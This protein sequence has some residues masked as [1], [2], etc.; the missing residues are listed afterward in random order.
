MKSTKELKMKHVGIICITIASM[1]P[2]WFAQAQQTEDASEFAKTSEGLITDKIPNTIHSAIGMAHAADLPLV[3]RRVEFFFG[4]TKSG[5]RMSNGHYYAAEESKPI[6]SAEEIL[7]DLYARG[8]EELDR[9]RGGS[10]FDRAWLAMCLIRTELHREDIDKKELRYRIE[11]MIDW[12][13]VAKCPESQE[14]LEFDKGRVRFLGTAVLFAEAVG[15]NSIAN[16]AMNYAF[17]ILDNREFDPEFT[18]NILSFAFLQPIRQV[19]DSAIT[20]AIFQHFSSLYSKYIEDNPRNLDIAHAIMLFNR[21]FGEEAVAAIPASGETVSLSLSDIDFQ[22]VDSTMLFSSSSEELQSWIEAKFRLLLGINLLETEEE[23]RVAIMQLLTEQELAIIISAVD[24]LDEK[25][26]QLIYSFAMPVIA[27]LTT[28]DDMDF[29]SLVSN[30]LFEE[31]PSTEHIR[32][33]FY[34]LIRGSKSQN[35]QE[36]LEGLNSATLVLVRSAL[37]A[38]KCCPGLGAANRVYAVVDETLDYNINDFTKKADEL[39]VLH[40]H[41]SAAECKGASLWLSLAQGYKNSQ[42]VIDRFKKRTQANVDNSETSFEVGISLL[43]ELQNSTAD[44]HLD[45]AQR[46]AILGCSLDATAENCEEFSL[47]LASWFAEQNPLADL[48][49][50]SRTSL[51]AFECDQV[52]AQL[53]ERDYQ[54]KVTTLKKKIHDRYEK[55]PQLTVSFLKIWDDYPIAMHDYGDYEG[56]EGEYAKMV[57]LL[58]DSGVPKSDKWLTWCL[59]QQARNLLK[60]ERYADAEKTYREIFTLHPEYHRSTMLPSLGF[61]HRRLGQSIQGQGELRF[62]DAEQEYLMALD[63]YEKMYPGDSNSNKRV[64]KELTNLYTSWDKPQLAKQY[65]DRLETAV[66]IVPE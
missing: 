4:L 8:F 54:H 17:E 3:S 18:R 5:F 25:V 37:Q 43:N 1:V 42:R 52:I 45:L 20:S 58:R 12:I 24:S 22:D 59:V 19:E 65:Q 51:E 2:V 62:A 15:S 41:S 16:T 7:D 11:E 39:V 55:S 26:Q 60:L 36:S 28:E 47:W 29:S 30:P 61:L 10:D 63:I 9:G 14:E 50:M 38:Q 21:H 66:T 33:F 27:G 53:D 34:S 49:E 35:L 32:S 57:N 31:F 40:G 13:A 6:K 48:S 23:R 44:G 56:A 64:V 46:L